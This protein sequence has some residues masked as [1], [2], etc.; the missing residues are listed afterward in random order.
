[1][2]KSCFATVVV[3]LL[4]CCCGYLF[5]FDFFL[6]KTPQYVVH[7]YWSIILQINLHFQMQPLLQPFLKL[8]ITSG[9]WATYRTEAELHSAVKPGFWTCLSRAGGLVLSQRS[10][11]PAVTATGEKAKNL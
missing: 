7:S 8:K 5:N 10:L 2:H 11:P 6:V 4:Q 3:V 1:M 9:S